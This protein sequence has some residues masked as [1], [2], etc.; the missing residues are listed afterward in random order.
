[1]QRAGMEDAPAC[2]PQLVS[3]EPIYKNMALHDNDAG[4][5]YGA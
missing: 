3:R 4:R 5:E 1:M 2:W